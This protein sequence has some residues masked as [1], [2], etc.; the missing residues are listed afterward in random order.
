MSSITERVSRRIHRFRWILLSSI[1]LAGIGL[2]CLLADLSRPLL[3]TSLE[4]KTTDGHPVYNRI[5]FKPGWQEDLWV[6]QQSHR[7]PESPPT[8]WDRLVIRVDKHSQPYQATFYQLEPGPAS[9]SLKTAKRTGLRA[10]CFACHI[11]GP[12]AIRADHAEFR[13][14][15]WDRLRIAALNMRIKSYRD[16]TVLPGHSPAGPVGFAFKSKVMREPLDLPS[17][18][19]C[20]RP[21]G[22][23]GRLTL[24]HLS[25]AAFLVANGEM[26][27]WPFS[28]SDEDRQTLKNFAVF[29]RDTTSLNGQF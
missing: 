11:S 15:W 28:I 21:S 20:H 23:R 29:D 18:R 2:S 24:A 19:G 22:M 7:E 3:F 16:A 5:V 14:S 8:S 27:P 9:L 4:S 12:R 13:V 17:C 10:P 6:M 1:C 26:P 25:T